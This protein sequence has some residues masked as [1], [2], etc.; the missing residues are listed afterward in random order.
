MKLIG[1][2][3]LA[4]R[5][6]AIVVGAGHNGLTAAFYLANADLKV[7][8]LERREFV[9]GL[10]STEEVFPGF[11][12][13]V[14][15]NSSHNLDPKVVDDMG[16]ESHG[17]RFVTPN[18]SSFM[19]FP[20]GR[21]F[22]GWQE[23]NRAADQI[24]AF[25]KGDAAGYDAILEEMDRLAE[26]LNVSFYD[27]PPTLHEMTGRLGT[28]ELEHTF[29]KVIF[30]SAT[31][32]LA[33]RIKSPEVQATL[34]IVAVSGNFISPSTPG[35]ALML[36]LRPL[37]RGSTASQQGTRFNVLGTGPRAPVGGMG[38]I[39]DA[40]AR[41]VQSLGATIATGV[42]VAQV[43]C[44]QGRTTG[45]VLA[46]GRTIEAPIVV[47]NLN[48]KQTL[49]NLI[50]PG[51]LPPAFEERAQAIRM[52]GSVFKVLLALDGLPRFRG[53][54]SPAED[55]MLAQCG[56]RMSP[57]I[58]SMD[59]AYQQATRGESSEEPLI[60]GL[61]PSSIDPTMAPPG[62]HVMSLTTFH[63]PYELAG[64]SWEVERERF[65]QRVLRTLGEY[66]PNLDS[67]ILS[68]KFLSPVD[69]ETEFGLTGGSQT[70]GDI[71]PGQMFSMRPISGASEYRTPIVGLYMCSVGN[72]PASYVS[73]LPGH[74]AAHQVLRDLRSRRYR[75]PDA[76]VDVPF[77]F[78]P[79]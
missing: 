5:Y 73:G 74:N 20:G 41:S 42:A 37:Y 67:L 3:E 27:P 4:Q 49:L 33:E 56:F 59:L 79:N 15:A 34:G 39:T 68:H 40:M 1:P 36:F 16:L 76:R 26:V 58:R 50:P 77:D 29:Q 47:S 71:T 2:T 18:P 45:V 55:H 44:R 51:E 23:R 63:A 22:V 78:A 69:L 66:I 72:W 21:L 70:H 32:L 25:G 7:A 14:A 11:R 48:P 24:E 19:A 38:A 12:I 65:G 10:C 6:D 9:G 43:T 53:S 62:K 13:N 46:D 75:L 57:S 54:K 8:V 61:I 35:S 28:A 60:W 64:R 31:D 30:G 17:L 52:S